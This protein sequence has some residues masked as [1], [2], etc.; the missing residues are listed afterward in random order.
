MLRLPTASRPR[1]EDIAELK[2]TRERNIG[3]FGS[4][5]LCHALLHAGL[6]DEIRLFTYPRV[7]GKAR[8]LF[9][10]GLDLPLRLVDATSFA[11]GQ[12]MSVYRTD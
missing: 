9:P 10:D 7:R 5:T 3:V 12:I 11:N 4:I 6:V 2:R 1:L 8:R